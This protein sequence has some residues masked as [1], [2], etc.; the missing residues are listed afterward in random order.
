MLL[1][2]LATDWSAHLSE[3]CLSSSRLGCCAV[4]LRN[5]AGSQCCLCK[6]PV[7]GMW[8]R[9]NTTDVPQVAEQLEH[10]GGRILWRVRPDLQ[11]RFQLPAEVPRDVADALS[12]PIAVPPR[13]LKGKRT[14]GGL[15][16]ALLPA[17]PGSYPSDC[18]SFALLCK[19]IAVAFRVPHLQQ[20]NHQHQQRRSIAKHKVVAEPLRGTVSPAPAHIAEGSSSGADGMT[21]QCL[22]HVYLGPM[23]QFCTAVK[24]IV[25]NAKQRSLMM[26]MQAPTVPPSASATA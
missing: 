18:G 16:G 26:L 17:M 20:G 24:S 3:T 13:V 15:H 1:A 10:Q 19:G 11:M 7:P 2:D 6:C 21:I 23:M 14:S 9:C 4:W 25:D 12:K 8:R 5:M 22:L